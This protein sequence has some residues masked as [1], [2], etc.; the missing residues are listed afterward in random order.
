MF[1]Y[2]VFVYIAKVYVVSDQ[3]C[4][5][6]PSVLADSIVCYCLVAINVYCFIVKYT[7]FV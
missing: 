6:T 7:G 4:H 5:T 1:M 3:C 2:L